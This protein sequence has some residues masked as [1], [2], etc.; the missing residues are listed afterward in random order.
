MSNLVIVESPSKAKTIKKYLGPGYDVVASMGHV[1]DL[2]ENRL[3]VDVKHDFKPKY[4]VIKGKEKLVDELKK[5]A[6]NSDKVW[7]ATDPDREGE[8][9]SW[10]LAY[11]LGLDTHDVNRVTFNEITKNGIREGMAAPRCIDQDLV[12]AQQA[13]RI[14]DRLVG[15]K[16]SPFLA[17]VIRRGLSAGRVQSV[18]V[19]LIVDREEEI[20][21]FVPQEY[22]TIDGKFLAKGERKQF[23]A[24]LYGLADGTKIEISNQE[25]ADRILAALDGAEFRVESVKKGQRRRSPAPPF[26]TSTLQQEASRKLGFQARRTMKVAQE[27]Y[28]G[29]EIAGMGAVGLITYMRTD[30]LRIS[31]DAIREV[32]EYIDN[33]FGGKYVPDKER[34]FKTRA[35][36]Q[37]G[38]EAI[39][40]TSV[41]L[42]PEEIKGSLTSDQ[43]K[44]YSLIWKRFVACQMSNCLM[45]TTQANILAGDYLFKA[46]GSQVT[47]DGFTVLY[48]EST[49][50]GGETASYLP[51]MEPGT[52]IRA[53]E[54]AGNQ[55][56]T[57][58]PAHY[59][60]ASLIKALEENG[61][62]RPSTYAV[63]IS[64]ITAREYVRRE[65]KNLIP[66]ELGEVSTKVMK[67]HFP[68]IVNVRFTAQIENELDAVQRGEENWVQTLH[69][70]YGD[71]DKTLQK[72]KA[73]MDGVKITLKED[74]TDIICEKCGR[75]MVVKMGRYGK[76]IAC[77]GYP[78]CKNIKKYVNYTGALCPKCG[79]RVVLKRSKKGRIFYGCENYP[80]C[81][82]VSWDEP[83]RETCPRC[84][85]TLLIKK[86]KN[87][88]LY[89]I[90][91]DC[92]FEKTGEDE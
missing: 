92:G 19:R 17:K 40:P 7:L 29:V 85:K 45:N 60:A 49:E 54:W 6:A 79:G 47:F 31:E 8:A 71:F 55:H 77:P 81:D 23:S 10:H 70:F 56:F 9:I 68:K 57:Q 87:P 48:E 25:E 30:S 35:N 14:L 42:Q 44:L 82:F 89:C 20:R 2:P 63:T 51:V 88:K 46:S 80:N 65:G 4:T 1:R 66:T 32:R 73:D 78:E 74:Q 34:H 15:Y 76:F 28:E 27:L 62:G 36:A 72:A 84:G 16:L 39:R 18:A 13:R 41:G 58:P 52:P 21:A 83:S 91:P 37:D 43:Y 69:N 24:S 26:T 33:Q 50:K 64:T 3:S 61:I 67:E 38:H 11:L 75:Q 86:G 53:R 59:T 22:W 90:T 12:D 5:T